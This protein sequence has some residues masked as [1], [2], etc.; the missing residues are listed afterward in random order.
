MLTFYRMITDICK[1]WLETSPFGWIFGSKS[2]DNDVR[3]NENLDIAIKRLKE[4]NASY[5]E[6]SGTDPTVYSNAISNLSFCSVGSRGRVLAWLAMAGP[7]FVTKL[8]EEEP[9]ALL[10]L[11]HW[12]VLLESLK[13]LWWAKNAG[14]RLMEDVVAVLEKV[15]FSSGARR[16]PGW[17]EAVG[18]ARWEA[19]VGANM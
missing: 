3:V 17:A 16:W 5:T 10:I 7:D 11:I 18:W 8:K 15:A 2:P 13:D 4:L 1:H 19:G 12:A 9:M 14:K 6:R